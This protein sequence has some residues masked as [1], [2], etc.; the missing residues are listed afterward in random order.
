M[1]YSLPREISQDEIKT[2][3]KD[4]VVC[5]RGILDEDWVNRMRSAVDRVINAPTESAQDFA[6][7]GRYDQYMYLYDEDFRDL[8]LL[9]PLGTAAGKL[10]RATR[11][12]LLWDFVLVKEPGSSQTTF[13]HQDY[14]FNPADG[15]QLTSTWAPLDVVTIES[16]AVEYIRGSHRWGRRFE[17]LCPGTALED[18]GD[19]SDGGEAIPDIEAERDRYEII[20]FDTQPGDCVIHHFMTVHGAPANSSVRRRRALCH[21]FAGNDATY[22]I[23]RNRFSIRPPVEPALPHGARFAVSHDLF[24]IVW[25]RP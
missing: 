13:W 6:M 14:G 12:N 19:A 20:H 3:E 21:R 4:G 25:P 11:V 18:L 22:A 2:F 15:W 5:L 23:R 7:V 24:P 1:N 9:S 17:P 10:M 16:G 8:A